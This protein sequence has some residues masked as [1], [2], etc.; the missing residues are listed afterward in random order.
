MQQINPAL[1]RQ[2]EAFRQMRA[3]KRAVQQAAIEQMGNQTPRMSIPN[4]YGL[5]MQE[6]Y[7]KLRSSNTTGASHAGGQM[8]QP[9]SHFQPNKKVWNVI[10]PP[11]VGQQT[12][13]QKQQLRIQQE[14]LIQQ[15]HYQGRLRQQLP[16]RQQLYGQYSSVPFVSIDFYDNGTED[17]A[18]KEALDNFDA[19]SSGEEDQG[20]TGLS[21]PEEL[22]SGHGKS[23][24]K[25]APKTTESQDSGRLSRISGPG[26]FERPPGMVNSPP[27][28]PKQ[29]VDMPLASPVLAYDIGEPT[30]EQQPDSDIIMRHIEAQRIARANAPAQIQPHQAQLA[31]PQAQRSMRAQARPHAQMQICAQETLPMDQH[32]PSQG[33]PQAQL[34]AAMGYDTGEP[35]DEQRAL[36]E[37]LSSRVSQSQ[38]E[39][40]YTSDGPLYSTITPSYAPNIPPPEFSPT[41]P[42]YAPNSPPPGFSPTTPCYSPTSPCYSPTSPCY[43]PTS[44]C[45]SPTSPMSPS[46]SPTAP[47]YSTTAPSYTPTAA[48]Y[49][50]Q[51]NGQNNDDEAP[52]PK[53]EEEIAIDIIGKYGPP[54]KEGSNKVSGGKADPKQPQSQ[55]RQQQQQ[56]QRARTAAPYSSFLG[57]EEFL[58]RFPRLNTISQKQLRQTQQQAGPAAPP[59]SVPVGSSGFTPI[60]ALMDVENTQCFNTPELSCLDASL[61]DTPYKPYSPSSRHYSSTPGS[62]FDLVGEHERQEEEQ[63]SAKPRREGH[64]RNAILRRRDYQ[65]PIRRVYSPGRTPLHSSPGHFTGITP[66]PEDERNGDIGSAGVRDTA[67]KRPR[68]STPQFEPSVSDREASRSKKRSRPAKLDPDEEARK[69]RKLARRKRHQAADLE[70]AQRRASAMDIERATRVA[71]RRRR[72]SRP[73]QNGAER[74]AEVLPEMRLARCRGVGVGEVMEE[75]PAETEMDIVDKLLA[76]WT[77]ISF[78]EL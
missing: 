10:T 72:A 45:Y 32:M 14:W 35:T 61:H 12:E 57:S 49:A 8:G 65:P 27:F 54:R 43:S 66:V 36:S 69:E 16:P 30:Y 76:D 48:F 19:D 13:L 42:A 25:L 63:R 4:G 22:Q 34:P 29:P 71:K 9:Q 77:T 2:R 21:R 1:Q 68:L 60:A 11:A 47:V 7:S 62:E 46:Y 38:I 3:Q 50:P 33:W 15:Q 31:H 28:P 53:P 55:Q 74:L 56:A 67:S 41:S 24:P 23:S 73:E 58:K 37:W 26:V 20:K 17:T 78:P 52:S 51:E 59:S 6:C 39:P 40:T 75:A 70:E 44:P 5:S 18:S 64:S